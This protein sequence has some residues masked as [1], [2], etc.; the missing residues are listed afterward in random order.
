VKGPT[1]AQSGTRTGSKPV[2]PVPT[3]LKGGDET[4]C[5]LSAHGMSLCRFLCLT[6]Q[7]NYAFFLRIDIRFLD[8]IYDVSFDWNPV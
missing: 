5:F 6:L 2:E 3:G 8:V 1:I 7:G 4:R